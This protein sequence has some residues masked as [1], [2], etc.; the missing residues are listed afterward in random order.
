MSLDFTVQHIWP[1]LFP[2]TGLFASLE[3]LHNPGT[4]DLINYFL[5]CFLWLLWACY[6]LHNGYYNPFTSMTAQLPAQQISSFNSSGF[7]F[8]FYS[9]LHTRN[10]SQLWK[11]RLGAGPSPRLYAVF[12]AQ[13]VCLG[14]V[15]RPWTAPP[16]KQMENSGCIPLCWSKGACIYAQNPL[17]SMY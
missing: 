6:K 10:F 9:N 8:L 14:P 11:A 13:Q 7:F 3:L 4:L 1:P 15:A 12:G 17:P 2:A 5:L 16:T